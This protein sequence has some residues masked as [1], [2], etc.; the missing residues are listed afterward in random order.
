M[1]VLGVAGFAV[2]AL[3]AAFVKL[4]V[5]PIAPGVEDLQEAK[6]WRPSIVLAA[7]GSELASFRQRQ[8]QWIPLDRISPHVIQ[9]LIATE[10]HRF[11]EH[12]GFDVGRTLAALLHTAN[13]D[14]QGGST[15]TQQLARNLFPEEIGRSR[16]AL[17]KLKE[18]VTA[19]KIERAYSKGQILETYLNTVPF[20]Y[21]VYGIEMAAQTYFGK[22]AAQL[23][24]AEAATLVGMLKGT[25]YYNP[26]V[27][28]ERARARR[29]VVLAQMM[30]HG[31]MPADQYQ[32]LRDKPLDI[33]FN[34]QP[35]QNGPSTHFT[36]YVRRWV[37]QWAE[38]NDYDLYTDGLVIRTTLDPALQEVAE[39]AVERQTQALQNIADVEWA[40]RSQSLLSS[41]PSAYARA[42]KHVEPFSYFWNTRQELVDAF[43]RETP[44]FKKKIQAGD[45]EAQAL[46][47]LKQ[48]AEF[49]TQL[50]AAKTRL[51]AGFVAMDPE[52]GEVKA[53]V[54]SR[55]FERDQFDHV[56]QA[57]RQ[58]GSTFKPIVYGAALEQGF[59]PDRSY[60]DE[61]VEIRF[62]DGEVWKPTD[63]NAPS[64]RQMTMREGLIF[65][66]NAI[67]AQ[68]MQD[69]GL[70]DIVNLAKAVG[71][72]QSRLDPVPS[73]SLGTSPVTLLEMV[74]AYSTIAQIGEFRKPVVV[75]RITDRN[76]KVIAE[77]GKDT[78]RAM[79]EKTAIEL[80][81]MMRGV[82]SH[83]TGTLVKAQFGISADIAGKT[84]TTQ[85]N[86]DG[87]FILMHPNLVAGSWIGFNDARVTMRS[88]YWGQGGHN[89]L[90]VVGDFFRSALKEKM[91]NAK[92][93]FPRPKQRHAPI[94]NPDAVEDFDNPLDAAAPRSEIIVRREP[95]GHVFIGDEQGALTASQERRIARTQDELD[96]ILG[97]MGRDPASGVQ[98]DASG[99]SGPQAEGQ[100]AP[101]EAIPA[102][103]GSISNTAPESFR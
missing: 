4:V 47:S 44:Q 45:S 11:Y 12:Q 2:A 72:T 99:S 1:K 63:M 42:R 87:W 49:M 18:I 93:K 102:R 85:Y 27:N 48:N 90:L 60:R 40:R 16:N 3:L 32:A 53:W 80:I 37:A 94:R 61:P 100:S 92:A 24:P 59:S 78:K 56:A 35:E 17:R 6:N 51:E 71:I 79:S 96:R 46:S 98:I 97:A 14:M 66:K 67:T 83:G 86:T 57:M 64:G 33:H 89:A 30:K 13:G 7:D 55:N 23:E 26:V 65:S 28:P 81:D 70:P 73:L 88:N 74:N 103:S 101:E 91:I 20:L 82:V 50:R 58:P 31:F 76:G 25:H 15:I 77:F 54:G 52:T 69:V 62:A 36:E 22:P 38:E 39:K 34:R 95:D 84:G 75:K 8:Q 9:A 29:N 10:D 43:V 68:V 19:V 5:V 41:A 21:N